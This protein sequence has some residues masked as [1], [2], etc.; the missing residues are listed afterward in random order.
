MNMSQPNPGLWRARYESVRQHFLQG[1][2][3]L[4]TEPLGLVLLLRRGVAGWMR[5][6]TATPTDCEGP[7]S[8]AQLFESSP[9]TT[10]QRQHQLTVVLAQMA[11][12]HLSPTPL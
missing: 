3:I 8:S 1:R 5:L 7:A 2:Q 9:T 11:A 6:W 4:E 12:R 10:A